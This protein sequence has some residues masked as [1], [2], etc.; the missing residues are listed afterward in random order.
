MSSHES[1]PGNRGASPC[2]H[3]VAFRQTRV[4]TTIVIDGDSHCAP[5]RASDLKRAAWISFAGVVLAAMITGVV[6]WVG[7]KHDAT[8][9]P[10]VAEARNG[11][12]GDGGLGLSGEFFKI[13]NRVPGQSIEALWMSA[14]AATAAK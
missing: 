12:R 8:V 6:T 7:V 1:A 10:A 5:A 2:R 4:E 11:Q 13:Q 3:A 9:K 14:P